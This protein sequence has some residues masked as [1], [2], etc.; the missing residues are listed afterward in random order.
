MLHRA[1][2][3]IS[4]V[5]P[6]SAEGYHS[7]EDMCEEILVERKKKK[8]TTTTANRWIESDLNFILFIHHQ[9]HYC[10]RERVAHVVRPFV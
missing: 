6:M 3:E 9:I 10:L 1:M 2:R 7:I 4:R 5:H 8:K